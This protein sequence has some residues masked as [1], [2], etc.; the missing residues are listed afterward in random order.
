MAPSLLY[1]EMRQK[2]LSKGVNAMGKCR[3]GQIEN[4]F[5]EGCLPD[6]T[7][8]PTKGPK[9]SSGK[10]SS[11]KITS[12]PETKTAKSSFV[13][14]P[15]KPG[16]VVFT[17]PYTKGCDAVP[18]GAKFFVERAPRLIPLNGSH[19]PYEPKDTDA[20]A[21]YKKP[22]TLKVDLGGDRRGSTVPRRTESSAQKLGGSRK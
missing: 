7:Y 4:P 19:K 11:G 14:C 12:K 10:K 21:M 3:I 5:G 15:P 1:L 17:N 18:L 2:P 13:K 8:R 9:N 22:R 20:A 6:V 16:Y